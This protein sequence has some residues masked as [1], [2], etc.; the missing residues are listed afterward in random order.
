MSW[1]KLSLLLSLALHLLATLTSGL[2]FGHLA[3]DVAHPDDDV[4]QAL[5][6]MRGDDP[7]RWKMTKKQNEAYARLMENTE[8]KWNEWKNYYGKVYG[9]H[10]QEFRAKVIFQQNMEAMMN[11]NARYP[12]SVSYY[13][14]L[15]QFADLTDEKFNRMKKLN[16]LHH[17]N[18]VHVPTNLWQQGPEKLPPT[19]NW[20]MDGFDTPVQD[21]GNCQSSWAFSAVGAIE[22][23]L[24]RHTGHLLD[25]SEQ[26]VMDCSQ[27]YETQGCDG[28]SA[29]AAFYYAILNPGGLAAEDD[30]SYN[31]TVSD[32]CRKLKENKYVSPVRGFSNV[33]AWN[34]TALQYAVATF[35]PVAATVDA[36]PTSFR[37]Y[38][39]GV[40]KE[41]GCNS[42]QVNHWVLI[43]G[44]GTFQRQDYWLLK[45]S[46]GR[47]WGL[48]GYMMLARNADNMCGI[49]NM[50]SFPIA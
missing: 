50:A 34:E 48:N 22:A 17:N 38:G 40:Y 29:N 1:A 9:R 43:V 15:N 49:T 24:F 36:T 3:V 25:L 20:R 42:R 44:Y 8:Q 28:G 23:Q 32:K 27:V 47:D 14:G 45:N 37:Q 46:W 21:E 16:R 4:L 5:N 33:E 12:S 31:A 19:V 26:Q 2:H 6:A 30:Y 18:L 10:I 7:S 11:H 39:G 13:K 41:R 35:G